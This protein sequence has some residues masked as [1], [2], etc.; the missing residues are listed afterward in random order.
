MRTARL[1]RDDR[2]GIWKLRRRLTGVSPAPVA[3]PLTVRETHA[4]AGVWY[5]RKL[6]EW[7]ADPALAD[8]WEDWAKG[9]PS[10]SLLYTDE[11]DE[12]QGVMSK[13]GEREWRRFIATY[14]PEVRELLSIEGVRTDAASEEKLAALIAS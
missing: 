11:E 6:A 7:E 14:L 10:D 5:Q 4:L 2:T 9:V 8:G 3:R 13:R 12:R 1:W